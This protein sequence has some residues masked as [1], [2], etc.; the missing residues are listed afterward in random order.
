[1]PA[2]ASSSCAPATYSP[3]L[4]LF[5][6]SDPFPGYSTS[7]A[8]QNG[9]SYAHNNPVNLTD[10]SGEIAIPAF[11]ATCTVFGVA[12]VP[13][14]LVAGVIGGVAYL[15]LEAILDPPVKPPDIRVKEAWEDF[16]DWCG[17]NI[18]PY[19][20][21]DP[22][23]DPRRVEPQTPPDDGKLRLYHYTN[24][25]GFNG[26]KRSQI[27]LPTTY[28]IGYDDEGNIEYDWRGS[29]FVDISPAEVRAVP[30]NEDDG[31][32]GRQEL[33]FYL[34]LSDDFSAFAKTE[35]WIGVE[36]DKSEV[37][38]VTDSFMYPKESIFDGRPYYIYRGIGF[39][40][41]G[42]KATCG[43]TDDPVPFSSCTGL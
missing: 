36:V 37:E 8:S 38:I 34:F 17:E 35:Y 22:E 41:A 28:D 12:C 20:L 15:A 6:S 24:R 23:E 40:L 9:Y 32:W 43:K 13:A 42:R 14:I 5:L 39:P 21:P 27:I 25:E 10:P 31:T 1:M 4:K 16:K 18:F 29:N 30:F 3:D 7:S 11:L 19:I 26:I 2:V 33:A